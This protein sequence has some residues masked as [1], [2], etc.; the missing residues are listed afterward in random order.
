MARRASRTRTI[1][2]DLNKMSQSIRAFLLEAGMEVVQELAERVAKEANARAPESEEPYYLVNNS[3]R[4]FARR[5]GPNKSGGSD[6]G[7]IRGSV[8]AQE[9]QKVPYSYLVCSPSWYSHFVEY[10]TQMHT[11]PRKS[12]KGKKMVFP[13]T[14]E[15]IGEVIATMNVTHPG[16][17]RRPF[18]RPAADM[19]EEIARE[20]LRAKGWLRS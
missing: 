12:K 2:F 9:S 14:N 10:G 15:Y 11:M 19:A 7:P 3:N 16:A 5:R 6:S 8:F 1:G 20:I 4:K 17:R 13:G 18:M